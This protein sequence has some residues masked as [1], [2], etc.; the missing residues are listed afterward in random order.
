MRGGAGV[1][2]PSVELAEVYI[3]IEPV[4]FRKQA[5]GL[6]AVVQD[7]LALNPFSEQIF[8]FTNRRR[9]RVRLLMWERNGFVLWSKRLER[10]RFHWPRNEG[11]VMTLTGQELNWL[12]DGF[13]LSRWQ[14]HH[15]LDYR[16]VA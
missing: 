13:D 11:A 14:P 10:Q 16:W 6:A 8:A 15:R 1:I 3:C 5:A 7:E 2:R 4:D 9:D 12:L